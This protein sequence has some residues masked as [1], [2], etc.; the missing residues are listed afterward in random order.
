MCTSL[1]YTG[2]DGSPYFGRTLE[3]DIDEPWVLAYV[4]PGLEFS[5]QAPD[6]DP[7]N[8]SGKH[9]F[10]AVTAP[11]RMPT[12]EQP[13]TPSDLKVIEGLNTAG[14]TFSLLAYPSSG[15]P[16]EAAAKTLAAI[17]AW[18][19]GA[20][21]LSQFSSVAEVKEGLARQDVYLTRIALVGDAVFPFHL[22]VHDK[23]GASIVIEWHEGVENVYDNPTGVM[24][25]GPT[26]PWHLT[27]L[28]NWTHLTNV[29]RSNAT[30]GSLPVHQPDSGIATA[31]LPGSHTSVDRFIR[32]VFYSTFVEK[33]DEPAK[34]LTTLS[35]IMDNFDRPR[36]ATTSP[37]QGAGGE[38]VTFQGIDHG[39]SGPPTEYTVWTNMS[40]LAGQK[41]FFRSYDAFNWTSFDLAA[42]AAEAKGPRVLLTPRLD[43]MGGDGTAALLAGSAA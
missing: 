23:S 37:P 17:Q 6:S 3:L 24:T 27:N 42:I 5:S 16:G 18:D 29:D 43:P 40:D 12:K 8:F 15:A 4:P 11:A 14:V 19:L 7:V 34:A 31:A 35:R 32:A 30:F 39:Q 26:F 20:W 10:I 38:G 9:G 28:G 33:V 25:N 1:Q 13:L 21:V 36:G 2:V 41:F 22:V